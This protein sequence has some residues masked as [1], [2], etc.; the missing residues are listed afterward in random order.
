MRLENNAEVESFNKLGYVIH[1]G[2]IA[3]REE[4]LSTEDLEY[5]GFN[6]YISKD[7]RVFEKAS[8]SVDG[9]EELVEYT[10]EELDAERRFISKNLTS[11][12]SL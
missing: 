7:N 1:E 5:A 10:N 11:N 3:K 12:D 8:S 6:V 9:K 2:R 4:H